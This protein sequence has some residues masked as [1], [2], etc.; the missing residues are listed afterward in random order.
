MSEFL[1][2]CEVASVA[3]LPSQQ[4]DHRSWS[5]R[6]DPSGVPVEGL[7]L[8][9]HEENKNP[10]SFDDAHQVCDRR[11]GGHSQGRS[12]NLCGMC[13]FTQPGQIDRYSLQPNPEVMFQLEGE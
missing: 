6:T 13:F 10:T 5:D 7:E 8:L 9:R 4:R 12:H 3:A 2:Q 1:R 11:E